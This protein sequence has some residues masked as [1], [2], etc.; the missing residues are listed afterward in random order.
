M[1]KYVGVCCP[2]GQENVGSNLGGLPGSEAAGQL[3]AIDPG[4]PG[5]GPGISTTT[6]PPSLDPEHP[7]V[8]GM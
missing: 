3:P 5:S 6:A 7:Q 4:L 2:E 1:D 8:R